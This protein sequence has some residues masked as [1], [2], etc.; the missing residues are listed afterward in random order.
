MNINNEKESTTIWT[1]F[2][3]QINPFKD[4][5]SLKYKDNLKC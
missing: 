3:Q 1:L 2:Q 5:I 4:Q